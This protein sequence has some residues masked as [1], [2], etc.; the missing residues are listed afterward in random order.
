MMAHRRPRFHRRPVFRAGALG[1]ADQAV[2]SAT[3]FATM[4]VLARALH[5]SDFGAFTL[6]YTGLLLVNGLQ[7]ALIT[8]PHNV[9]A[10]G[11]EGREYAVYTSSTA[12]GQGL[13][14]LA[15]ALL[16]LVAAG[17]AAAVAPGV[18]SL[19]FALVPALVTWQAQE[20]VRRIL[21]SETRLRAALA[22]DVVSYGGQVAAVVALAAAGFITPARALLAVAATS[23]A[24]GLYGAWK[25]RG[26]LTRRIDAAAL[27]ENWAFGKWIGAG[28]GASWLATQLYIYV[29]A[30][31]LGSTAAGALRAAQI[32]LG[33]LNAFFL[34]LA[35]VLPIRFAATRARSGDPGLERDLRRATAVTTPV[36]LIYC[37]STA[38]FATALLELLY[39]A[40]YRGYGEVVVLFAVY[41]VV[42]Q[43]A[44]LL[45]AALTAKRLTRATFVGSAAG[46]LFG[47]VFGW[48]LV[49]LLGIEGAVFGMIA[50]GVIVNVVFW[51]AYRRLPGGGADGSVRDATPP[52][53]LEV[54]GAAG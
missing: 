54:P 39:G 17:T 13:F 14:T 6:A 7:A 3:N 24:G 11:R 36:V 51:R 42:L 2:I 50:S 52:T 34:F 46:G 4:V 33:P 20:F 18:A 12:V 10:Q 1:L 45:T 35:L 5:P 16:A 47:V 40:T 28:I 37:A 43:F 27:R 48:P 44:Y 32:V 53:T 8:Q 38:L 25:V 30:I 49:S 19:L 23:A 22:V 15:F 29:A 31:V 26:S 9:L 21:Y 41:Y